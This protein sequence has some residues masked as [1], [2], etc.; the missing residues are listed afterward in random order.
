MITSNDKPNI[1]II[2]TDQQ[3]CKASKRHGFEID[4]TPYQDTMA[5][6]GL[7]FD[8]G[9]TVAPLCGP[10]RVSLL[11]GRYP[12]EHGIRANNTHDMEIRCE[13][14]LPEVL[15]QAGYERAIIGK[16]HTPLTEK[17]YDFWY[18]VTH[19][20]AFY[21]KDDALSAV[22]RTEKEIKFDNWLHGLNGGVAQE[23]T[24]FPLECQLPWR[25]VSV[26][27]K[28][29]KDKNEKPFFMQLSI[30]EPHSP[31]QVPEPYYSMF[32]NEKLPDIAGDKNTIKENGFRW[33]AIKAIQDE[34]I[35]ND[36]DEL[37]EQCRY[38]Y[39]GMMRLIDDQI[40]R[41]ENI[42][43]EQG[44]LENTVIFFVADHGDFV[45]DYGLLRK[46]PGLPE[47]LCRI[48]FFV[49]GPGI[50]ASTKPHNA[51]VNLVD[52]M[53]TICELIGQE[54]PVGVQGKSLVPLF[55]NKD[56]D[57]EKFDTAYCQTG[58][59]GRSFTWESDIDFKKYAVWG[60]GAF[61]ELNRYVLSGSMRMVRYKDW[62]LIADSDENFWLYNLQEDPDETQNL[63]ESSHEQAAQM[64]EILQ[65]KL[66]LTMI[67]NEE[68]LSNVRY[69]IP[70]EINH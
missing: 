47:D 30:P 55:D 11:T 16:N 13:K 38:N 44:L 63:I 58:Y 28:W 21:E 48:P 46:G 39:Y 54:I 41:L 18:S 6:N 67:R 57:E 31:Y 65:Q 4:T 9:Y 35:G 23:S 12:T 45:G 52:V 64:R 32:R 53:P 7:W 1:I 68:P 33:E 61:E 2:M 17:D 29:L 34:A 22:D 26:A 27:E 43:Q 24:S 42:L 36:H 10:A 70:G 56:Y 20:G 19:E 5:Q 3:Q 8:K 66:I 15:A 59:G 37:I 14:T 51:H 49:K 50:K 25:L 40:K 62:K 60:G 69:R